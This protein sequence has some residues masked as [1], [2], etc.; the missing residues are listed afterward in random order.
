M[1]K[2]WT[3]EKIGAEGRAA[4]KAGIDRVHAPVAATIGA[5]GRNAVYSEWGKSKPTNDGVSI[6]DRINPKD[7]FE[8]LGANLIKE[9]AHTTVEQAGDG[10]TSTVIV[11][12]A[13]A[14]IGEQAIK[15]GKDPMELRVE[16]DAACVKVVAAI[17][18][19]SKP[20]KT[21]D[22]VLNVAKVS[23]EDDEMAEIV[24]D[25]VLKA[26]KYGAVIVEEGAG[27]GLEKDEVKGY[28]WER[29]YV[30]PY[31][32]TNSESQSTILENIPVVVTD[33]YMN[34]NRDLLTGVLNE[35]KANG[36]NKALVI[37]DRCE[38]ELLQSLIVNKVKGVFTTIV[39]Q[40]PGTVDELQ[41]IATVV[42]ATAITKDSGIK[43]INF[44]H[45]GTADKIIVEENKTTI[46]VSKTSVAVETRV[47]ELD[48]AL[49]RAK[50]EGK[51]TELL[52][53]RRAKLSDGIV[54]IRV[55]AK[56]E[57]ERKYKKDKLDDAVAAA[58]A[59]TEEGIVDGGGVAFTMAGSVLE[60]ESVMSTM[61]ERVLKEALS[62]PYKKIIENAGLPLTGEF[63][64]VKTGKKVKDM[65]KEGIIDPAKVT[66]CVVENAV[67]FAGI[68]LTLESVIAD[69]SEETGTPQ[70]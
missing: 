14:E 59:A 7:P 35:I 32:I 11:S 46:I 53:T 26:G 37:L 70:V 19:M 24:T 5:K 55:G 69:F 8:R 33:R 36:H 66:R 13:L 17:K 22:D 51:N 42:G 12:H 16:L 29:G 63:Y 34:L 30:S 27:Y 20:V 6:A 64:N 67:T 45:V 56:T 65:V 47:K 68:Y 2:Y 57:A 38:G 58:K 25:A 9:A 49:A 15:E 23:V 50:K 3:E 54:I 52:I 21:R 31:M 28:F 40:R 44:S 39:V 43:D 61:G 62:R 18:K 41:D 10:T 48:E 60:E 4:L 1:T